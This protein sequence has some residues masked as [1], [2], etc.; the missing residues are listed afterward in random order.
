MADEATPAPNDAPEEGGSLLTGGEGTE[1]VTPEPKAEPAPGD[2]P[3]DDTSVADDGDAGD[4]G[5]GDDTANDD[6]KG[7]PEGAPE[8]YADFSAPEGVDLNTDALASFKELAKTNNL[9][10]EAAQKYVDIAAKLVADQQQAFVDDVLATRQGW[11]DAAKADPAFGGENLDANLA[12]AK[13]GLEAH[14]SP[15][16]RKL[17]DET[18]LGNHPEIIRAFISI[19]KT[20]AEDKV[21]T[22]G[23]AA[24][25]TADIAERLYPTKK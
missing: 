9:T 12:I 10:Q 16:L 6:D 4:D 13:R 15:E 2:E 8:E 5:A 11:L 14:A 1:G 21:V 3:K 25:P 17:F 24:S 7:E 18:G 22:G 23:S 19:G 20:V